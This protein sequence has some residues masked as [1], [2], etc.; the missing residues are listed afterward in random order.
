MQYIV[1]HSGE[2]QYIIFPDSSTSVLKY[3]NL[4][5]TKLNL[6]T[7]PVIFEIQKLDY[8]LHFCKLMKQ[9]STRFLLV[10]VERKHSIVLSSLRLYGSSVGSGLH[11]ILETRMMGVKQVTSQISFPAEVSD[12]RSAFLVIFNINI[13]SV[14]C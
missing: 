13:L 2:F 4:P 11:K 5:C 10:G 3:L 9:R 8:P 1:Y 12:I 14:P 7:I 6:T